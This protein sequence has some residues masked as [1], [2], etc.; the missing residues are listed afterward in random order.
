MPDKKISV[1]IPS[2]NS[3]A[4][5]ARCLNSLRQQEPVRDIEVIVV[6]SSSDETGQIISEQF[7]WVRL[8]RLEQKTDQGTARNLGIKQAGGEILFFTDADCVVPPDWVARML[9][10]H[11]K[12][13][14][15]VGGPIINADQESAI[16][17]AGYL[18]E[19]NNLLPTKTPL[20]VEHLPSGNVSYQRQILEQFGGFPAGLE[21]YLEDLLFH[22]RMAEAGVKMWFDPSIQVSHFHR[23]ELQDYLRHQYVY[24]R[25][26]VQLLR[27]TSLPGAWL[28]KHP[29]L[30][31]PALPL[32]PVVKFIRTSWR[33]L[34]WNPGQFFKKPLVFPVMGLGLVCWLFGF[35]LELYSGK[36]K[37]A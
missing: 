30:S 9:A 34:C 20:E 35:V 25:G 24:G 11:A 16:G 13:Y 23:T 27:Q 2:Y 3:A 4:T 37:K 28:T 19:F 32:L 21:Y 8:M 26:T 1:I 12:G 5:I 33:F 17:W 18:L 22:C 14:P 36:S 6:D 15:A 29:F 31:L 10:G 7:P